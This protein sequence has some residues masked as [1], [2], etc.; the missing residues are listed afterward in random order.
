MKQGYI[1]FLLISSFILTVVWIGFTIYHN[2]QTS[3][4]SDTLNVEIQPITAQ[5]DTH[6]ISA[7]K[8]RTKV[9][10]LY[11]LDNVYKSGITEPTPTLEPTIAVPTVIPT[12]EPT[13]TPTL[14]EDTP[15]PTDTPVDQIVGGDTP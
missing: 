6:T 1:L 4:I 14:I 11:Q 7:I 10:P 8:N 15:I 3:T 2:I 13:A 9:L 12:L 5:F